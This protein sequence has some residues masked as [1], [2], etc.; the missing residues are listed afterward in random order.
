MGAADVPIFIICRDRVTPLRDLVSWLERAGHES[1]IMIDNASTYEPLLE[2]YE[3]TPHSVVRLTENL[4]PYDSVWGGGLIA[5]WARDRS[6]VVTDSDVV[7]DDACPPDAVAYLQWVLDRF[8]TYRKSGLGLRLDDVPEHYA[9]APM[10]REWEA[11]FWLRRIQKGLFRA[12]IDTTF[13]LYRPHSGFELEPAIRT[14]GPYLARHTPWYSNLD[15]LTEE[16]TYYRAH[17]RA[18]ISHW[19]DR[20]VSSVDSA[21]LTLPGRLQWMAHARLRIPR[22]ADAPRRYRSAVNRRH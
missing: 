17:A 11:R 15:A 14:G 18:A 19:D 7:P 4:G 22:N 16:D 5:E 2:Y 6:Y 9:L 10:V 3:Q 21:R 8:P 13:A 1:I 12:P 20:G